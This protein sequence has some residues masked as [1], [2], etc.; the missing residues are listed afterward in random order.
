M[1][2]IQ[3]MWSVNATHLSLTKVLEKKM[4]CSLNRT[5]PTIAT[6]SLHHRSKYEKDDDSCQWLCDESIEERFFRPCKA[7]FTASAQSLKCSRGSL[8]W[9]F[10]KSKVSY[11]D[12][13]EEQRPRLFLIQ[14]P[15]STCNPISSH[16][17]S[18]LTSLHPTSFSFFFFL[19][20]RFLLSNRVNTGGDEAMILHHFSL[21]GF[22]ITTFS[23]LQPS[24]ILTPLLL[25][26]S[27]ALNFVWLTPSAPHSYL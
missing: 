4:G 15:V 5:I 7:D 17:V 16:F 22:F 18:V 21:P 23:R 26:S 25:H 6:S 1:Q 19:L 11:Y 27:S 3:S 2:S 24:F 14:F 10:D 20:P 8:T 12:Y 9:H 13:V